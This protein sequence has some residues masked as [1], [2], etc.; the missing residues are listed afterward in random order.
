MN[1][2]AVL[3]TKPLHPHILIYKCSLTMHS[4]TMHVRMCVTGVCV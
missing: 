1:M 3:I 4:S 2:A